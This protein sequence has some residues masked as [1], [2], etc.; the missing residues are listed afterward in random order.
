MRRF[1]A[2]LVVA[3][4]AFVMAGCNKPQPVNIEFSGHAPFYVKSKDERSVRAICPHCTL[5]IKWKTTNCTHK[6]GDRKCAGVITWPESVPCAYC[7][8]R[9][10]CQVCE[11]NRITDGKCFQCKGKGVLPPGVVCPN[12]G[13]K[14]VCPVCAGSGKC[15]FCSNGQLVLENVKKERIVDPE[16]AE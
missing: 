12:C 8:G 7:K 10:I 3:F 11:A 2:L 16:A 5:H 13:G 1:V 6:I 14:K 15:D 9:N 4:A